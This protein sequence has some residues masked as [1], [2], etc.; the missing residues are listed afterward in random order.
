VGPFAAIGSIAIAVLVLRLLD[1]HVPPALAVGLFPMVIEQ[2][3]YRLPVAVGLDTP[4]L[5]ASFLLWRRISGSM[6]RAGKRGQ[7]D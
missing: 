4:M 2:P 7:S 5:T 1:L 3:D 6:V